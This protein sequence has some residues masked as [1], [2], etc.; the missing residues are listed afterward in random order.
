MPVTILEALLNADHNL[1]HN[2]LL[3]VLLAKE[4]LHNA[5]TLLLKGYTLEDRVEPLIATAG[6]LQDV[7]DNPR[8]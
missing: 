2:G 5:V 7:P 3:G 1:H 4:Q 8:T 6:S